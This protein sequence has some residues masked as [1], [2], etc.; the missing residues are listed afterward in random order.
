M[1]YI[2]LTTTTAADY[3]K[4][5]LTTTSSTSGI[6]LSNYIY[7]NEK[8]EEIDELLESVQEAKKLYQEENRGLFNEKDY[9][10]VMNNN[11]Y[12]KIVSRLGIVFKRESDSQIS[13]TSTL[14][15]IKIKI[16]DSVKRIHLIKKGERENMD[17]YSYCPSTISFGFLSKTRVDKLPER[18]IINSGAA[19]LFWNDGDKTISKRDA[20]DKFD[21]RMGFL[22]AYYYKKCG[23]SKA[24]RKRVLD[25]VK[26]EKMF[27]FLLEFFVKETDMDYEK[28][29]KYLNNLKVSD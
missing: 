17:Y 27:R 19:V 24:A 13:T 4:T 23:V 2:T 26:E 25:C 9:L 22:L 21:K 12:H 7:N 16:D 18:Y 14:Y 28:A 1:D 11:D 29:N 6:N 20:A 8:E 15:G 3:G 10:I 5:F